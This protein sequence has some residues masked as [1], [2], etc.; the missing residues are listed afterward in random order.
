MNKA[1]IYT[2]LLFLFTGLLAFLAAYLVEYRE[3]AIERDGLQFAKVGKAELVESNRQHPI[4]FIITDEAASEKRLYKTN[5]DTAAIGNSWLLHRTTDMTLANKELFWNANSA[6]FTF[7]DTLHS[8]SVDERFAIVGGASNIEGMRLLQHRVEP[9]LWGFIDDSLFVFVMLSGIAFFVIWLIDFLGFFA[10][11][12]IHPYAQKGFQIVCL[13]G[14]IAFLGITHITT[15][16]PASSHAMLVRNI[17]F[18]GFGYALFQYV[19]QRFVPKLDFLDGE[20]VKFVTI[21]GGLLIFYFIGN[22][23]GHSIDASSHDII[24]PKPLRAG[25]HVMIGLMFA[26]AMGNLLNNLRK[27]WLFLRANNRLLKHTK[28]ESVAAKAELKALQGSINP[29]FLYNALN[30]IASLAKTDAEKTEQMALSLSSFYQYVTNKEAQHTSTLA[31]ELEMV[32]HYL[33]IEKVRFGER[34]HIEMDCSEASLAC[35]M[36]RFTLQ[37]LVENA[38]KYGFKE[39]KIEV[40]IVSQK[41]ENQLQLQ[42]FDSG[43]AFPEHLVM[44]FGLQHVTKKLRLLFPEQHRLE[45]VHS[46]EKHVFISVTQ[47]TLIKH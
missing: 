36:P 25:S 4:M 2:V 12:F 26:F 8:L 38:I 31:E 40:K 29:H 9:G 7:Q 19:L 35:I 5:T 23:I 28:K 16:M 13:V 30:S 15:W 20:L 21:F 46:P 3:I 45:F 10:G 43:K 32:Q 39:D 34:L 33:D 42:V 17:V 22:F 44:G 6:D 37:P 14:A 27:R 41:L 18:L 1:T 11:Q 47:E 24:I